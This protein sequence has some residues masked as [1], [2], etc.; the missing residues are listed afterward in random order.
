VH[1]ALFGLDAVCLRH[2]N[3]YGVGQRCD[4]YGNVIS[5]FAHRLLRDELLIIYGD[6][7]QTRDLADVCDVEAANLRAALT[8]AA[9]GVFNIGSK[10]RAVELKER[11]FLKEA[12]TRNEGQGQWMCAT[13][14]WASPLL[15]PSSC[16][17]LL[18]HCATGYE[19]MGRG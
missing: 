3:V 10:A 17:I 4:V 11:A 18:S 12:R 7:E 9:S 19:S 6:G 1:A 15:D 13:V 2:F 16:M 8:P 14:W 5:I